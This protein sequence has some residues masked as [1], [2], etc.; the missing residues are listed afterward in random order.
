M[1]LFVSRPLPVIPANLGETGNL[2]TTNSIEN[3][4][5]QTKGERRLQAPNPTFNFK[6]PP[7]P[8]LP[9]YQAPKISTLRDQGGGTGSTFADNSL[10]NASITTR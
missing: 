6:P 4:Y 9:L 5:E 7:P 2:L 1:T 3:D 8:N 10:N